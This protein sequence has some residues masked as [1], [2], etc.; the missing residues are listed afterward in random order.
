VATINRV[1]VVW[2]G[3]AVVGGGVSTFYFT[4]TGTG[5]NT[6]V[7]NF[8][9][10]IQSLFPTTVSFTIPATGEQ[11]DSS[12]GDTTGSWTDGVQSTLVGTATVQNY[13][14]GVGARVTWFTNGRT[15][16][17]RVRGTTFL[18]PISTA[19]YD[20]DGTLNS[21]AFAVIRDNAASLVS[22]ASNSLVIWTRPN[23]EHAGALNSV[24]SSAAPDKT[25]WLRT[26][27]T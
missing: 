10:G 27:K 11:L 1:R 21:T 25:S 20:T 19:N 16:N 24:L 18:V 15:N 4:G 17:R 6:M 12:T 2:S 13:A 5:V 3:S 23:E 22:A 8:F 26:R 9:T 14:A 7:K